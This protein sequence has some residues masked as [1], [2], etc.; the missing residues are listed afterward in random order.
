MARL[1]MTLSEANDHFWKA[2][3][4]CDLNFIIFVFG[5]VWSA[6][7]PPTKGNWW[8]LLL[9]KIWLLLIYCVCVL[10]KKFSPYESL[11]IWHIRLENAYARQKSRF[12]GENFTLW[13]DSNINTNPKRH[14]LV[15]GPSRATAGHF[16]VITHITSTAKLQGNKCFSYDRKFH[17]LSHQSNTMMSLAKNSINVSDVTSSQLKV[18]SKLRSA[19][20]M[21]PSWKIEK[22]SYLTNCLTKFDKI[23]HGDACQPLKFL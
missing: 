11:N 3:A 6:F 8:S 21:L 23:W 14:I 12:F 9:C 20:K 13:M 17:C 15:P 5:C 2:H 1:P 18:S 16:S 7:G 22:L 19:S 4:A 10:M